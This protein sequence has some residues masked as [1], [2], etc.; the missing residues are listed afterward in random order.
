[1]KNYFLKFR[2]MKIFGKKVTGGGKDG[3]TV[4]HPWTLDMN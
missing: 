3:G 4:I 2:K 1:M